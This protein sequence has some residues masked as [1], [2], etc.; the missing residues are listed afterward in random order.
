MIIDDI[1]DEVDS[2]EDLANVYFDYLEGNETEEGLYQAIEKICQY[3]YMVTTD[4][5]VSC[6]YQG[7]QNGWTANEM[8]N[9]IFDF[10]GMMGYFGDDE[11]E[12]DTYNEAITYFDEARHEVWTK[13]NK[14]LINA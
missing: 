8:L 6:F 3:S 5:V 14:Y 10:E 9:E 4:D 1:L 2:M 7:I 11:I 13:F 12:K